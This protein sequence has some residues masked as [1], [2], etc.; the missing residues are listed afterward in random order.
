M[1]M[2]FPEG[3]V[4]TDA[5]GIPDYLD[6]DSDNDGIPDNVEAQVSGVD[7]DG[8]GIDDIY[9]VDVTGGTDADGDGVDD[10]IEATGT[11]DSDGD[12]TPDALDLDSDND[13]I[14]DTVE[15]TVI[16]MQTVF[17]MLLK[18]PLT[19]MVTVHQITLTPTQTMTVFQT[20]R[21]PRLVVLI[22]TVT[23]SMIS[24]M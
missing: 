1:L 6:T 5:D 24:M 8:D 7:T 21:K 3:T 12:G 9:D 10:A 2:V 15:G 17:R 20:R 22:P 18:A 14:P 19:M 11:I 4:D 23:A 16:Q 13:G